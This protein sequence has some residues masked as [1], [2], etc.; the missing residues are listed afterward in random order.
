[1]ATED[2]LVVRTMSVSQKNA[3]NVNGDIPE[4]VIVTNAKASDHSANGSAERIGVSSPSSDEFMADEKAMVMSN[5]SL[6]AD[7]Q[8][9]VN[10]SWEDI[11]VEAE[12]PKPSL[13]KR[14]FKKEE[15]ALKPTKKQILFDGE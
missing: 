1:M 8:E 12:L 10:L 6:A 7:L 14:C 4:V 15:L 2:A 11:C 13:V 5:P 3:E 9:K